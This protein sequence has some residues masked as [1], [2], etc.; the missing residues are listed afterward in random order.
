MASAADLCGWAL[1]RQAVGRREEFAG[2]P[3]M[4]AYSVVVSPQI[5]DFQETW[6]WRCMPTFLQK[7]RKRPL[8]W[9]SGRD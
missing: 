5:W 8:A 7:G 6:S 3:K 1:G 9:L 4:L 2:Q